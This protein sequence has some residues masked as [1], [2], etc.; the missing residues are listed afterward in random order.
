MQPDKLND[1]DLC[2]YQ[3]SKWRTAPIVINDRG[4]I[5]YGPQ[6]MNDD[7]GQGFQQCS[8]SITACRPRRSR[9]DEAVMAHLPDKLQPQAIEAVDDP[10]ERQRRLTAQVMQRQVIQRQISR[11]RGGSNPLAALRR[12]EDDE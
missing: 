4:E 7:F 9:A 2:R 1:S 10:A 5:E 3:L 6:K 12:L 8:L 11:Q